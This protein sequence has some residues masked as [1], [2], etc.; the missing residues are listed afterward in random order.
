MNCKLKREDL[1]ALF[2]GELE[3]ADGSPSSTDPNPIAFQR[4]T[5]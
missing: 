4:Y 5:I 3:K 2:Y 1:V